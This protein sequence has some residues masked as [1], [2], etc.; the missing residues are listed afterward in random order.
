MNNLT[1]SDI[2]QSVDYG[3]R[4]WI[5]KICFIFYVLIV[6]AMTIAVA[7]MLDGTPNPKLYW[8]IMGFLILLIPSEFIVF[9]IISVCKGRSLLKRYSRFTQHEVVLNEPHSSYIY[10]GS[11]YF[12]VYIPDGDGAISASTNPNFSGF[13]Y[14]KYKAH[15]YSGKKVVGL[16]DEKSHKFYVIKKVD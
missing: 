10:R 9:A 8:T 6:I 12:K 16:L 3:W 15:E 2:K 11:I 1:T 5:A 14:G 7:V 13:F 4:M